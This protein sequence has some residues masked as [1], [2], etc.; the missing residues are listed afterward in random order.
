MTLT[1]KEARIVR[2]VSRPWWPRVTF[3]CAI[4]LVVCGVVSLGLAIRGCV[5]LYHMIDA[6]IQPVT[7][8]VLSE[9]W[10]SLMIGGI[11]LMCSIFIWCARSYG[12]LIRKL[13]DK[14]DA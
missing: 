10:L 1:A 4:T 5:R 14:N 3:Y 2:K 11:A 9:T 12:L 13:A 6:G 7:I 8:T